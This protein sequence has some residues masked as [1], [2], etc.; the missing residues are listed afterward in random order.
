VS[1]RRV[2]DGRRIDNAIEVGN[3]QFGFRHIV[4]T[5]LSKPPRRALCDA[6]VLVTENCAQLSVIRA[7]TVP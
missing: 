5:D 6:L 7:K 2:Y 3:G 4:A 1:Q